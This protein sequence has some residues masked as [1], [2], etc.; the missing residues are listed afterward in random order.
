M[1]VYIIPPM[2]EMDLMERGDSIFC[3]AQHYLKNSAYRDYIKHCQQ[4]GKW[5]TLDS[6]IGDYEP[7]TQQELF[8]ATLDLLPN[9]V[10]PVDTLFN[11]DQTLKNLEEFKAMLEENDLLGVVQILG[12]P[13]GETKEDWLHCYKEMLQDKHVNTIGFSK[14]TVP[15]VWRTG[16]DD[17]GIMEGRHL[18]Y[19]ELMEEGLITKPIHCL[20]AGDPREFLL[21][22]D[23]PL[24]RSTD[25]CFSVW[26]GMN[27]IDWSN[28]DFTRIKTPHDYFTRPMMPIQK[29]ITLRNIEFLKQIVKSKQN[30]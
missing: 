18:C 19:R 25:S 3:L 2:S 16:K 21:Y 23:N 26:A 13:Q 12:C 6:G 15:H 1:K 10:I 24:M 27:L 17:Q 28:G 22:K 20:G 5:I 11:S 4:Q 14:I 29:E 9:E 30:E 8:K 7:V